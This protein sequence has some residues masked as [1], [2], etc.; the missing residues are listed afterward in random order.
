VVVETTQAV[1]DADPGAEKVV[2]S[3]STSLMKLNDAIEFTSESSMSSRI[4]RASCWC[5]TAKPTEEYP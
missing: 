4:W 1:D 2:P 5:F 3:L